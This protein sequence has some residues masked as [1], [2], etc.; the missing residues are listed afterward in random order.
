MYTEHLKLLNNVKKFLVGTTIALLVIGTLAIAGIAQSQKINTYQVVA[1]SKPAPVSVSYVYGQ[2]FLKGYAAEM[3]IQYGLSPVQFTQMI[4]TI[5]CESSWNYLAFNKKGNS[6][7]IAQYQPATFK[8]NCKGDYKDAK[9]QIS[10]MASM[11][12]RGMLKRWDC[13]RILGFVK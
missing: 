8:E 5:T 13:A 3:S 12:K 4:E 6:Y 11:I 2:E 1:P 10:C 9:A 7:G